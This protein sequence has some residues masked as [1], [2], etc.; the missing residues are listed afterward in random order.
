MGAIPEKPKI[1]LIGTAAIGMAAQN[2]NEIRSVK[3]MNLHQKDRRRNKIHYF[4][5]FHNTLRRTSWH[6]ARY[7][8]A[9]S[10]HG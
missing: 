4:N 8:C 9:F 7:G 1:G 5:V 10:A 2:G 3:V 6:Q